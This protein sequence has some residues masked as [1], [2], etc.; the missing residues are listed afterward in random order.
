MRGFV[1]VMWR[2]A[3]P[4]LFFIGLKSDFVGIIQGVH[5]D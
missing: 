1:G 2:L 4:V 3:H 5:T